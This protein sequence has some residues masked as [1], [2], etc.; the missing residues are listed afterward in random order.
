[1]NGEPDATEPANGKIEASDDELRIGRGAPAGYLAGTL[2]EVAVFRVA[3]SQNQIKSVIEVG[4][5]VSLS[6]DSEAR[7]AS[8]WANIKASL[9][10]H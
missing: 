2:D 10:I 9:N 7:L 6:V 8:T 3:L 5:E 4:F 1:V